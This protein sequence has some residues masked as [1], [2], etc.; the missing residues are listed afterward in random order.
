MNAFAA[1]RESGREDELRGELVTL[2]GAQNVSQDPERT[3]IPATFLR[4]TAVKS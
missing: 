2:F 3:E 1:A 4:V